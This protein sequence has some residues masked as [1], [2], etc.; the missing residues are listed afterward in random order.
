[1]HAGE[2]IPVFLNSLPRRTVLYL[3]HYLEGF[4]FLITT[5]KHGIFLRFLD[6]L[7]LFELPISP[8]SNHT[9]LPDVVTIEIF[10][11]DDKIY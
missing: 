2:A 5:K 10:K 11:L 6:F 8:K 4:F 7:G 1:M 3:L 9:P